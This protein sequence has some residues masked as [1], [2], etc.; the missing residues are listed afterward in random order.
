ME[1]PTALSIT[2]IDKLDSNPMFLM[3]FTY[4][5]FR[6]KVAHELAKVSGISLEMFGALKVLNAHGK[7]TQ[8]ELSN[9]LLRNRSVTKRL[10]DNAIKLNL[11]EPS[12]SETNKKVKLL[13]L[14]LEGQ[15]AVVDCTPIVDKMTRQHQSSLTEAESLQITQLLAKLVKKDEFVD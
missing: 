8:Q 4:K 2:G 9:L 10:V 15:K 1:N 11:I 3:G 12:K 13:A 14:T 7:I 6:A 5:Q